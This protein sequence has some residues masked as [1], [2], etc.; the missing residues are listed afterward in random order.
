M[1]PFPRR[2][3]PVAIVVMAAAI[4]TTVPP[5]R[6]QDASA[7]KQVP[8]GTSATISKTITPTSDSPR[9]TKMLDAALTPKTRQTLQEA[10]NSVGDGSSK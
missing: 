4:I 6:A 1:T 7:T 9:Q 2:R 3:L 5:V 10:M 8:A